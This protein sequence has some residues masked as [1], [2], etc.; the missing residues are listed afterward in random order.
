MQNGGKKFVLIK[1]YVNLKAARDKMA[2][3]YNIIKHK[4]YHI[5]L[6]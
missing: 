2:Q 1:K 6:Y 5:S 4:L 3:I